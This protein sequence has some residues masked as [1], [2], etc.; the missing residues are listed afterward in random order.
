MKGNITVILLLL[1]NTREIKYISKPFFADSPISPIYYVDIRNKQIKILGTFTTLFN[2]RWEDVF[3]KETKYNSTFQEKRWG[4]KDWINSV[5]WGKNPPCFSLILNKSAGFVLFWKLGSRLLFLP[6][7]QTEPHNHNLNIPHLYERRIRS[8][9]QETW[10][11]VVYSEQGKTKVMH[12]YLFFASLSPGICLFFGGGGGGNSC[13][14]CLTATCSF[15]GVVSAAVFCET[16]DI[17]TLPT[18][19]VTCTKQFSKNV[20]CHFWQT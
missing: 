20:K 14:N 3:P 18:A 4:T 10:V 5:F 2:Q 11:Y 9:D 7:P 19:W 6:V 16:C 12:T 13:L 8:Q 1:L 15:N 17:P